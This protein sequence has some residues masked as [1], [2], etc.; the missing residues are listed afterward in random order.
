MLKRNTHSTSYFYI[1]EI[2]KYKLWTHTSEETGK[3][4]LQTLAIKIS[5]QGQDGIDTWELLTCYN[6]HY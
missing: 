2:N 4:N 6:L 3:K 1:D 5:S